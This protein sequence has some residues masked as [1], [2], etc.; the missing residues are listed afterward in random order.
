MRDVLRNSE[1]MDAILRDIPRDRETMPCI[2]VIFE[3]ALK[4]I[5]LGCPYE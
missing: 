2:L 5:S 4:L 3:A 1:I